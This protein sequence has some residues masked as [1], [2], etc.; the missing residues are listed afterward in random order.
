[1]IMLKNESNGMKLEKKYRNI[2]FKKKSIIADKFYSYY[3]VSV[4]SHVEYIQTRT[5]TRI[6]LSSFDSFA[7]FPKEGK[8]NVSVLS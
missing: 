6:L 3:F 4:M 5:R 8:N 2:N 1:M 7:H